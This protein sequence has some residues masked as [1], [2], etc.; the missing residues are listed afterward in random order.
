MSRTARRLYLGFTAVLMAAVLVAFV[1]NRDIARD[2]R[3]PDDFD[4]LARWV[5]DHPADW[6]AVSLIADRSLDAGV[7]R[8][9]ELWRASY[10][11]ASRLA[12]LRPNPAAAFTRGGLFHWYELGAEDRAAVLRAAAPL[13][14]DP[15]TFARMHRPLWELTRDLA[16]LR[17]H[18]PDSERA[19]LA[20][21]DIAVT[22]GRFDDYRELRAALVRR[23]LRTFEEKRAALTPPELI[24]LLPRRITSAYDPLVRRVLE[25]LQRRPLDAASAARARSGAEELI[26]YALRHRIRP[27]DGLEAII[28]TPSIRAPIRARL[29][30]ALGRD[31]QAAAIELASATGGGDWTPYFLERAAFEAARGDAAT[32]ALYRRRATGT[33]PA[34]W[35]GTCGRNEVCRTATRVVDAPLALT[36]QNAQ[37]DEVPPYVELYVD[38]MLVAEGPVEESRRFTVSPGRVELRV[39]NPWTRN[40]FQR[41]VRLS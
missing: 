30:I 22:N 14:R 10:A 16:Y 24:A 12:P 26:A 23:R 20:L 36:V 25:E 40:R 18:A 29:A 8:R 37:S 21:R 17:R 2:E 19:L 1:L 41:R 13:L 7:P 5:A 15:A 31:G 4:A 3:R 39:V 6:L 9:L 32:A 27:L 28:E 35:S 11:H 38:D 33:E 34:Q